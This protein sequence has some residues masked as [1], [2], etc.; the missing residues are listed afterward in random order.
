[1]VIPNVTFKLS[2]GNQSSYRVKNYYRR[3]TGANKTVNHIQCSLG[4]VWL[5]DI[6]LI[7]IYS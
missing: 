6:K 1:M 2:P 3:N 5:C 4:C 7:N